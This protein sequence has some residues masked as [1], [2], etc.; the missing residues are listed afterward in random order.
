M[1]MGKRSVRP[2]CEVVVRSSGP[3]RETAMV[4]LFAQ[5]VRLDALA[6]EA[7][8]TGE[9]PLQSLADWDEGNLSRLAT[10]LNR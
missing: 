8:R 10:V 7:S 4:L 3:G 9:A 5:D 2:V 6:P 1:I